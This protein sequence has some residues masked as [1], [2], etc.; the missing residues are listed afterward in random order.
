MH[1]GNRGRIGNM[2]DQV[3][4]HICSVCMDITKYVCLLCKT[5]ICNKF[6][7]FESDEETANW[8]AGASVGY[9]DLCSY[10]RQPTTAKR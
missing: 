2:A 8:K 9:C 6:A 1:V 3:D 10:E 4:V 7:T 5:P